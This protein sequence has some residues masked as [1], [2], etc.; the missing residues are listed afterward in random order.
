M[1]TDLRLELKDGL[2][3][4]HVLIGHGMRPKEAIAAVNIEKDLETRKHFLRFGL[5]VEALLVLVQQR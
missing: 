2:E 3:Q 1:R 5:G 4:A